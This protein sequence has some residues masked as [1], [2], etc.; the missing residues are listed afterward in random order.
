MGAGLGKPRA[1]TSTLGPHTG[2]ED[3]PCF[4]DTGP[5]LHLYLADLSEAHDRAGLSGGG[6][7]V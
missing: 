7:G 4:V 1:P 6:W 3:F 5:E 2:L